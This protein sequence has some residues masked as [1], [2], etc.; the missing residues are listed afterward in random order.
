MS[1]VRMIRSV[2]EHPAG[3]ELELADELAD[4]F[5]LCGYAEG[6]LSRE[7]SDDERAN[8]T[9]GHQEVSL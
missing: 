3:E 5:V 9:D 6:T 2:D 8:I 7:Y 4:R 1:T